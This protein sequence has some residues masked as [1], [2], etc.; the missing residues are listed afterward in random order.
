MN[1]TIIQVPVA[2]DLRDKA[3]VAAEGLGFSSLQETIRIF[4]VNL[5]SGKLSIV[6]EEK[7]IKLSSKAVKRYNE[8]LNKI[9]AGEEKLYTAKNGSEL[10]SQLYGNKNKLQQDI[11]KKLRKKNKKSPIT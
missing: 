11:S 2:R 7:P 1:K 4:L 3:A 9:D 10:I 8:M 6:F 5:A